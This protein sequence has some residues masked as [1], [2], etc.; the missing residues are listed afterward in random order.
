VDE[1]EN[2]PYVVSRFYR[3]PE[4]I[5]ACRD[6]GKEVDIWAAGCIFI[7]LH[8][9]TPIF[10]GASDGDQLLKQLSILGRIPSTSPIIQKSPLSKDLIS[11]LLKI[12]KKTDLIESFERSSKPSLAADLAL[13]ML[14]Y[15]PKDRLSACECLS[16]EYFKDDIKVIKSSN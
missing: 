9:G 5:L 1:T 16:H 12:G 15:N 11:S 6:Y 4:L 14:Q 3:A 8:T 2:V 10:P 13:K 7:E